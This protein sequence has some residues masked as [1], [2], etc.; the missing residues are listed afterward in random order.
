MHPVPRDFDKYLYCRFCRLSVFSI[1]HWPISVLS[2]GGTQGLA[3]WLM[4][5]LYLS[6]L[7]ALSSF[8]GAEDLKDAVL[9]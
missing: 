2:I 4:A 6:L 3:D 7:C 1:S 9:Q 8:Y 5:G